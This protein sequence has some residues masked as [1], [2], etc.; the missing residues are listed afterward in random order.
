MNRTYSPKM[1]ERALRML[2][3]SRPEHPTL[4]TAIRQVAGM[5]GM[6]PET[7]RLWQRRY[8][9]DHGKRSGV[10]TE[11]DQVRDLIHKTEGGFQRIPNG[12]SDVAIRRVACQA[13]E[14]PCRPRVVCWNP[15]QSTGAG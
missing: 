11:A 5:L 15:T 1:R 8:E 7:L 14:S 4:M 12:F 3:E 6:S 9:V 10:T 2:A 13:A